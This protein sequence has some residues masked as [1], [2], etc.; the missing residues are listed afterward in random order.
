LVHLGLV[1]KNLTSAAYIISVIS[2]T[3]WHIALYIKVLVLLL[4]RAIDA[5]DSN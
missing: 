1:K 2:F 4:L 3:K 5:F